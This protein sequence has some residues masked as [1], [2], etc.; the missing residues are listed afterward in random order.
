VNALVSDGFLS[1]RSWVDGGSS[2]FGV[3]GF[4]AVPSVGV[5]LKF[6]FR[7]FRIFDL[8]FSGGELRQGERKQ[9]F[10]AGRVH[11]Y[12]ISVFPCPP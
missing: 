1:F 6:G 4:M 7:S 2:V 12:L 11:G 10:F 8:H 3:D 9:Q 5:F